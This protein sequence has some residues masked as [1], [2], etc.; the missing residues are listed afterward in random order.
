MS[1][2]IIILGSTGSVGTSA[3]NCLDSKNIKVS[4]LTA[5]TN[6]KK[7]FKQSMKFNVKNAIIEDKKKY[8]KYK[9]IFK[10]KKINLHLGIKRID[11]ILK[12]KVNFCINSISGIEGLEPT[13]K[14]IPFTKKILIANKE[15]IVCGW[16]I[17]LKKLNECETQF[18]PL[19]SEHF[20]IWKLINNEKMQN[21]DK[22]VLT[23]SGGPFL[24]KKKN[25][26]INIKP[27]AALKHPNWKMGK[28]ISIDS[29]T[30][31][32]KIFEYIEA[33]K[34]FNLN[35][36]KLSIIIQPS[37]FIHAIVYFK[38]NIIKLLAHETR[39]TIP[40]CNALGI[41][42]KSNNLN[43]LKYI[44]K[45][46]NL[47]FQIPDEK[48]FPLLSIIKLIPE[49]NS[50]FETILIT[51][52]DNL[53]NKYLNNKINYNSIQLNILK[54]IKNPFFKKYYNLKP[55]NIYDIN[56]MIEVTNKYIEYKIQN[57][58]NRKKT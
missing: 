56:K 31:M 37:S 12:N 41:H 25:Q 33:K 53:V 57:Y 38:G 32:N 23:A 28:K 13:L 18:I 22:I 7:L 5:K 44:N 50:Y 52:N 8:L 58:G 14:I 45:F 47:N 29:S 1:Q 48:Q 39:M 10:K 27:K 49:N 20:S 43:N 40:I 17:I 34:I 3:L 54:L 19:D 4:M 26:I 30:M 46:N 21:V 51:I 55:K 36:K 2:K 24:N 6:V 35:K 11:K 15:T 9:K 42:E 16:D